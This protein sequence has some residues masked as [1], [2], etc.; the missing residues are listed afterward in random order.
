[1]AHIMAVQCSGRRKGYT[2][3][4]METAAERLR[5]TE[6][7]EVEVFHLHDYKVGPCTS[8]FKCI[9]KVGS[10]CVL[11]DDWGKKGYGVLYRAF[12]RTNGL[13][14]V[15]PVHT[16]GISAAAHTFM[17]RIYPT[18]WEGV[19]YGLPFASVSCASN[20]G[21]QYRATKDFCR[22]ACG[23]GF[24][25]IG[26][27]PVHAV[28]FNES[29]G[30]IRVL[31][32]KLAE[33]ALLDERGGRKKL[34]DQEIFSMYNG[35]IWDLV[36]GYL[37]NLTGNSFSYEDS[38]PVK[39]IRDRLISNPEALLHIEKVCVHLKTALDHYNGGS[40]EE[41]VRELALAAK[42]WTNG[43]YLQCCQNLTVNAKI[44]DTYRPLDETL[45]TPKT[46]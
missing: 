32:V 28:H 3:T 17:E 39:A 36:D 7:I 42:Y 33:A 45:S 1:M 11:N 40:R 37:Q 22:M 5:E 14:M 44:P 12:K 6:N 13:L 20:Q 27:I 43:T 29:R 34:T 41:A 8:C 46:G 4:L 2:A 10:G 19:P 9:R 30:D 24:R 25:Y 15:D 38:I 16:W 31:A 26:G 23:M 21:F 35:A 18:F